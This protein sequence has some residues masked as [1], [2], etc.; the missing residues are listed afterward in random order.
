MQPLPFASRWR[1]A[2]PWLGSLG[3]HAVILFGLG[4]GAHWV[5]QPLAPEPLVVSLSPLE[6]ARPLPSPTSA[7]QPQLQPIP[8]PPPAVKPPPALLPAMSAAQ[9]A[10]APTAVAIAVAASA[11]SPVAPTPVAAATSTAVLT[12]SAPAA[13]T[14]PANDPA[15]APTNKPLAATTPSP[16]PAPS[17]VPLIAADFKTTYLQ[18]PKPNYP[19]ISSRLG[20]AGTVTLWVAVNATGTVDD[21]GILRSSGFARLDAEALKAVKLWRFT[22]ARRG[23]QA[24]ADKVSV[25]IEFGL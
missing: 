9:P 23:G 4:L 5:T 1:A 22:P 15:A 20:E 3:L 7:P 21:L 2:Q 14:V 17:P 8:A 25:P 11:P 13:S 10:V 16:A 24:V 6:V 18:N 19:T 12:A